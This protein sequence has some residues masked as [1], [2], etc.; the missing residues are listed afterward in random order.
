MSSTEAALE[1]GS[2]VIPQKRLLSFLFSK[3]NIPAPENHERKPY[4]FKDANIINRAFFYWVTPIMNVGYNRTLQPNDLYYLTDDLKI[5][6][7]TELY[8]ENLAAEINYSQIKHIQKKCRERGETVST[9]SVSKEDDLKDFKLSAFNL[10]MAL[11]LTFKKSIFYGFLFAIVSV[12]TMAAQPFLTK[13]LIT[14]VEDKLL[15]P[16]VNLGQGIGYAIGVSIMALMTGTSIAYYQYYIQMCGALLRS[17][18]IS[19]MLQK[20]FVLAPKGRHKFPTSKITSLMSTDLSRIERAFIYFPLFASLPIPIVLSIALLV[21]NVGVAGVIGVVVFILFLGAISLS[22]KQLYKYRTLVSGLTDERI[23]IIREIINNLKIIKFYS[24]EIPYLSNIIKARSKEVAVILKIQSLRNV[25]DAVSSGLTGITAMITFLVLYGLEGSTRNAASMFSSITSFDVLSFVIYFIPLGL[26]TTADSWNG[27]KRIAEYLSA[28]EIE[29]TE[30]YVVSNDV[31]KSTAI[32]I[33]NASFSWD[34]FEDDDEDMAVKE[35]SENAE[36]PE[37][38]FPGLL[39]I[40]LSVKKG[41]FIVITG[42]IGSGKTSLLSAIANIMKIDE[43]KV[44]INGTLINCAAPWIHNATIKDNILFGS[45]FEKEKYDNVVYACALQTDIDILEAGDLTEVGEKGITLS[46]GQKARINLARAVY[47]DEDIILLDDVLSAVDAR[48][49][50]HVVNHCMLGLLKDKTRL[51][52]T[53][54]LS[55]IGSA[56]R[57]IYLNGDGSIDVGTMEELGDTNSGFKRLMTHSSSDKEEVEETVPS[58]PVFEEADIADEL[59]PKFTKETF[60]ESSSNVTRRRKVKTDEAEEDSEEVFRDVTVGKDASKGKITQKEERAVNRIKNEVYYNFIK[61]GS[62]KLSPYVTIPLMILLLTLSTF[63]S[64]FSNTW[65]S[66]WISKKFDDRSNS[67]YIGFYVLFNILNVVFLTTLFVILANITTNSSKNLI[68]MAIKRVLHSPMSYLDVTPMGRIINRFTKDTDTLDNEIVENMKLLLVTTGGVVG[69]LILLIIYLPWFAIAMPL[70][71]GLFVAIASYYQASCREIKRLEAIQ[72]SFVYDNFNETLTG[73]GTIKAYKAENFFLERSNQYMN[74]M[75]E[76]SFLVFATQRWLAVHLEIL[77]DFVILITA[78]LCVARVFSISS[79]TAGLLISYSLQ[80]GSA[81]AQVL[82]NFVQFEN[83]MNS[84]ERVCHYALK[85]DQEAPYTIQE[86]KPS[87]SWPQTGAIKFDNVSMNYRPGLPLVLKGLTFD[88]SSKQKIG[89]CGRTGAG[90][91]SI[92]TVLY[93]I[94]ELEGGKITIDGID[95]STLGLNELRTKLSI[96]PQDPVLFNGTIRNNLDPFGEHDD[97]KLFDAIRRSGL[98]TM[99]EFKDIEK[100]KGNGSTDSEKLHKFHLDQFV[101]DEGANFS[102]GERQLIAFARA[103]VRETKILILDEA[104][105]SVDYETDSKI[106]K[107]IATEFKDCTI[108]CIAHR[109]KTIINYDKIL[110][111]DRGEIKEFDTPWM[112]FNSDNGIFKQMCEKSQIVAGDF[113]NRD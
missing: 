101:E 61:Y 15:R 97:I 83:D 13:N 47:A 96:I 84:T 30:S 55:L 79:A 1:L 4:P 41:E 113:L 20:S 21:V 111:L 64:I 56:D 89:I 14:F 92:M 32:D 50:K 51:L 3:K 66:F 44:E 60:Q 93:R 81:L 40:N 8:K 12:T 69:I 109:L 102:L 53:H 36:K 57:I 67:F 108:L 87:S 46:G 103:L 19:L 76:A 37:A 63:S 94:C 80:I 9:T 105:S 34:K 75:N 5:E 16:S 112:L 78:L 100:Q 24:W 91:S 27:L 48:V 25:I 86:T 52:A 17:V 33:M 39:E 68:L 72:R 107:T 73:M 77:A 62:G 106:Q 45:N 6:Y 65:L 88:V 18:L 2:D 90:K 70:I 99:E 98:M 58:K 49:G 7:H 54:Q 95:I 82:R 35:E 59:I 28:E 85:L 43:G 11:A 22:T 104:T 42:S 74:T 71:G 29:P 10:L 110:T 23:R 31:N 26:S 38:N